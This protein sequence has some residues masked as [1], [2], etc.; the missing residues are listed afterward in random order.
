MGA[1]H[2]VAG[3][4]VTR[5]TALASVL[6]VAAVWASGC[7]G[8]RWYPSETGPDERVLRGAVAG[9]ERMIARYRAALAADE[10]PAELLESFLVHHE[11]HLGALRER[12]PDEDRTRTDP[13]APDAS[14]SPSP[15][16]DGPVDAAGLRTAEEASAGARSRQCADAEDPALAQLVASI[17]ACEAAHAH[18]LGEE[19]G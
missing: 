10:G 12:L 19:V 17:G 2:G 7:R 9:K 18:R 11:E 13:G 8:G 6:A 4:P 14:P 3:I 15:V 5:R 1:R 16:G